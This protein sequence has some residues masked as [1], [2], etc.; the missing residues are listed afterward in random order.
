MTTT[1]LRIKEEN[2]STIIK[3]NSYMDKDTLKSYIISRIKNIENIF[4]D[5]FDFPFTDETKIIINNYEGIILMVLENKSNKTEYY[6]FDDKVRYLG[7]TDGNSVLFKADDITITNDS[8][9]DENNTRLLIDFINYL[10]ELKN[11]IPFTLNDILLCANLRIFNNKFSK[12]IIENQDIILALPN[13]YK[14]TLHKLSLSIIS[15]KGLRTVGSIDCNF[16]DLGNDN[17]RYQGNVMINIYAGFQN[18]GYELK[19]LKLLKNYVDNSQEEVNKDIFI[20]AI[21]DDNDTI[22][23]LNASGGILVYD[24]EVPKSDP[25]NFIGKV[26]NIKIYRIGGYNE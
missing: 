15:K 18:I 4:D 5:I 24:G 10:G 1:N 19:T 23:I 8:L 9:D 13:F 7:I 16:N 14:E 17:F 2:G 26:K 20:A 6:L 3:C 21:P 22:N 11:I 12:I 25:L